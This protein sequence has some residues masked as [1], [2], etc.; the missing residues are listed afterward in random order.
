M[1]HVLTDDQIRTLGN[2]L[3]EIHRYFKPVYGS[4]AAKRFAMDTEFKFD[5]TLENPNGPTVLFM[6]QCR[7]Y[8]SD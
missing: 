4:N 3:T 7:P 1:S 8:Y 2:A 5:Q 6:K